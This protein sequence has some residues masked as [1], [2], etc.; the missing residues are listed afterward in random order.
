MLAGGSPRLFALE[1]IAPPRAQE[2]VVTLPADG[3]VRIVVLGDTGRGDQN[4][5]RVARAAAHACRQAGGCHLGA[6]LGDNVYPS[7]LASDDDPRFAALVEDIYGAD[8]FGF[9]FVLVLGNHDHGAPVPFLGGLGIGTAR[10]D[11]QVARAGRSARMLLP[12]RH[13]RLALGRIELVGLDTQDLY[14]DD[15]RRYDGVVDA[16]DRDLARW[17]LEAQAPFRIALGH[18]PYRSAGP[19][20]DAG[21]YEGLPRGFPLAGAPIAELLEKRV[22]GHF[23]LYLAG[24]DHGLQDAGDAKG[25]ALFVSGGGA[26]HEPHPARR[27]TPFAVASLGFV[28]LEIDPELHRAHVRIYGVS[29]DET[30]IVPRLL[31]ERVI[32]RA[33]ERPVERPIE[34]A[35]AANR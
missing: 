25:T 15:G 18:H 26:S 10:A 5:H 19:H 34:R 23:D 3:P 35:P 24:H 21:S 33:V 1:P 31:H 13:W 4:Q 7:G 6:L 20:G 8:D 16:Q 12:A 2:P 29:D 28:L 22:L 11:A 32:V 14:A 17:N 9:P 27:P 30:D